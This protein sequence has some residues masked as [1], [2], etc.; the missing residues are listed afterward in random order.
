MAPPATTIEPR[1]D[2][3]SIDAA[4]SVCGSCFFN[5]TG[6][7]ICARDERPDTEFAAFFPA[8]VDRDED[9]DSEVIATNAVAADTDDD[10]YC[11]EVRRLMVVPA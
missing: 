9:C 2:I 10:E 7:F 5:S 11:R 6:I 3:T 8:L 4:A 1:G